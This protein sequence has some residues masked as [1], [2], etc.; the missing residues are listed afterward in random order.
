M[1][2][3]T[4]LDAWL[5]ALYDYQGCDP[6]DEYDK[7]E[8]QVAKIEERRRADQLRQREEHDARAIAFQRAGFLGRG[9]QQQRQPDRPPGK[10]RRPSGWQ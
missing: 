5:R 6:G 3:C 7:I 8:E 10:R 4:Q 1:V 2:C 9:H